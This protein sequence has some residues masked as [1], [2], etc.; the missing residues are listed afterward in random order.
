MDDKELV[1]WLANEWDASGVPRD[2][3]S[4]IFKHW[5]TMGR[6]GNYLGPPVSDAYTTKNG[7]FVVQSFTRG[8]L[9]YDAPRVYMGMP[10][11]G[12]L[13]GGA[14]GSAGS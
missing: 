10:F 12:P 14:K 4:A 1:L 5:L 7:E 3:D 2:P 11:M 9:Y 13:G 6:S 8:E